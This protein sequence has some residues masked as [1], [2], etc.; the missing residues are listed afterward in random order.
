[1]VKKEIKLIVS[2]VDGTL[3]GKNENLEKD[4]RELQQVL[5]EKKL[6]FSI[7]S[8]RGYASVKNLLSIL[9]LHCPIILNNGAVI[10]EPD[11]NRVLEEE[12]FTAASVKRAIE[13]ADSK[14]M[15]ILLS[16][17]AGEFVYRE[18]PY[19]KRK[20]EKDGISYGRL[21]KGRI[22]ELKLY[23]LQITDSD[24]EG[25]IDEA[26]SGLD[27]QR[28]E[29]KTIRYNSRFA[30][31]MPIGA[32][33]YEGVKKLA[34][35]LNIGLDEVMTIGDAKNDIEM[36]KSAGLGAAVGN[37]SESLKEV[38]DYVSDHPYTEGVIDSIK[39]QFL[40]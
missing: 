4:L 24:K 2:D 27:L 19:A 17:D 9:S 25:R 39:A 18:H 36:V 35:Y 33:K 28:G 20:L 30:D 7:A 1:M 34:A 11:N 32:G 38:A 15:I 29:L 8:G 26:L 37:A 14:E 10:V 12:W 22:E 40:P 3:I 5:N 23:K 6:M 16:T 13:T 31:I 21:E